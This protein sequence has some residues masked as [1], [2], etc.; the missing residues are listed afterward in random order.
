[1]CVLLFVTV[2]S[3]NLTITDLRIDVNLKHAK[4]LS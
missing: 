4:T 3:N 1:M 2:E